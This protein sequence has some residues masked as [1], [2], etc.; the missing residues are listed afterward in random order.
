MIWN[1]WKTTAGLV[2]FLL[3]LGIIYLLAWFASGCTLP[4]QLTA[5]QAMKMDPEQIA[6]YK[7][8]GYKVFMCVQGG[9]PPGA[10]GLTFMLVDE[11]STVDLQF[12][13]NCQL[14]KGDVK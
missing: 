5:A 2:S 8:K 13:P 1:H 11:K 6:A 7:D 3:W 10:G 14:V 9:G 4:A 12:S